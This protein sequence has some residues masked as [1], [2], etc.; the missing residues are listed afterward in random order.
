MVITRQ[1]FCWK[2]LSVT[3]VSKYGKSEYSRA[4]NA[5]YMFQPLMSFWFYP[6]TNGF[7]DAPSIKL[8][9]ATWNVTW[10]LELCIF[11]GLYFDFVL[12]PVFKYKAVVGVLCSSI[13]VLYQGRIFLAATERK[14]ITDLFCFERAHYK[15]FIFLCFL[16]WRMQTLQRVRNV[17]RLSSQYHKTTLLFIT[18]FLYWT[19]LYLLSLFGM[20][21]RCLFVLTYFDSSRPHTHATTHATG[22]QIVRAKMTSLDAIFCRGNKSSSH[23]LA[24]FYS[25]KHKKSTARASRSWKKLSS[26]YRQVYHSLRA[27]SWACVLREKCLSPCCLVFLFLP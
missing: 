26:T 22:K 24:R 18:R 3:K 13:G 25:R 5:S 11:C 9:H 4:L 23:F 2:W 19:F 1:P 27:Q 21:F 17:W 10:S 14:N 7:T 8:D 20:F 6:I 16:S 15:V 12:S